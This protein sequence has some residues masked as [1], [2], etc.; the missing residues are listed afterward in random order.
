MYR[1]SNDCKDLSIRKSNLAEIHHGVV[2]ILKKEWQPASYVP[3]CYAPV[4]R[5]A[6]VAYL[7]NKEQ[8]R[9]KLL[10]ELASKSYSPALG[11]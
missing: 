7:K 8:S 6:V 9:E 3:L 4:D 11:L 10:S 5:A 2:Y 1:G